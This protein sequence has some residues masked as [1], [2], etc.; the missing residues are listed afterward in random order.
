MHVQITS[1]VEIFALSGLIK[2]LGIYP[3]KDLFLK[4]SSQCHVSGDEHKYKYKVSLVVSKDVNKREEELLGLSERRR[5]LCG[6]H[7]A[8]HDRSGNTH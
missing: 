5:P 1:V 3:H 7:A 6:R 4:S 2:Y 8:S